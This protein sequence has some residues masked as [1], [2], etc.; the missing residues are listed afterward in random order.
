MPESKV[1]LTFV[2][3]DN[4][5]QELISGLRER[6]EE[7]ADAWR[8]PA[9]FLGEDL[10][11]QR[12]RGHDEGYTNVTHVHDRF[13]WTTGASEVPGRTPEPPKVA[14]GHFRCPLACSQ[15][16]AHHHWRAPD[17]QAW[18]IPGR[19]S[20]CDRDHLAEWKDGKL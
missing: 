20:D 18:I 17:G 2:V 4:H 15:S 16:G 11:C 3:A 9:V 13:S 19:T 7:L 1:M 12:D 5:I 10:R 6:A 8:C 14:V